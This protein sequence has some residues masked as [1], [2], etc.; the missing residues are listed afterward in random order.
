MDRGAGAVFGAERVVAKRSY[1]PGLFS[2]DGNDRSE[3]EGKVERIGKR[4]EQMTAA[5][6]GDIHGGGCVE[7][8]AAH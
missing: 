1:T 6:R 4:R 5:Q 3:G 7:H 8:S 2:T